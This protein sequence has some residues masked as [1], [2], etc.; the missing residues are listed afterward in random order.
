[1]NIRYI[2]IGV[3]AITVALLFFYKYRIA[4]LNII[5]TR[6]V[7]NAE[8]F[9]KSKEGQLKKKWVIQEVDKVIPFWLKWLIS[10]ETISEMI[11]FIVSMLQSVFRKI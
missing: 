2:I 1:M 8:N 7:I 5:I 10:E 9:Y 3:I 11:E 4:G 6:L